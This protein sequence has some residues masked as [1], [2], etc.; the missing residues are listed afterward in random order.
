MKASSKFLTLNVKDVIK[1][2][3]TAVIGTLCSTLLQSCSSGS[4]PDLAS[5]KAAGL[6]G[7]SAG[8]IYLLTT[9]VSNSKRE[10]LKSES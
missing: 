6:A 9:F 10:V 2:V 5:L 4:L 1:G 3:W 7:V 8:V